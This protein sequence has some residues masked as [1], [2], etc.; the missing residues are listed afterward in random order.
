MVCVSMCVCAC[1]CADKHRAA[2]ELGALAGLTLHGDD[3]D[4]EEGPQ[5]LPEHAC[6]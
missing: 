5:E 4:E 1:V 6:R 3:S 2:A